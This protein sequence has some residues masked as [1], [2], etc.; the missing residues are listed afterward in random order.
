M[1]RFINQ[2]RLGVALLIF[3]IPLSM[4]GQTFN[5]SGK[6]VNEKKEALEYSSVVLVSKTDTTNLSFLLSDNNGSFEFVKVTAGSYELQILYNGYDFFEQS[7][8]LSNDLNLGEIKLQPSGITLKEAMVVAKKIPMVFKGDTIVYNPNS[9]STR[10]NASVEDLLKKLPGVQVLKDGTV[11]AQGENVVKVL[12]NGKE[13]FGDDPTKATKNIDADAVDKVEILERKTDEAR[14]K[15]VDDG[16]REK[17]I[18][19]VLKEEANKGYF[20]KAEVGGGTSETYRGKLTLNRFNEDNQYTIVAN[21]NNLNQNGFDWRE[22]Y[23][24]LG[25]SN[26]VSLGQKTYWSSQNEWLGQNQQGRQT[27]AVIGANANFKAGKK[28]NFNSS[29]FFM[30]RSNDLQ[31]SST[32][33]NFIPGYNIFNNSSSNLTSS[34]GQHKVYG[35]YRL[36]ADTLNFVTLEGE[37][38]YSYGREAKNNYAVNETAEGNLLNQ[39]LSQLEDINSNLNFKMKGSYIRKFR[40]NKHVITGEAGL[41]RNDAVDTSTWAILYSREPITNSLALPREFEDGKTGFGNQFFAGAQFDYHLKKK[42]FT[43]IRVEYK[44]GK[45][46]FLQNRTHLFND[47][48]VASQSPL[49]SSTYESV[50]YQLGLSKNFDKKGWFWGLYVSALNLNQKRELELEGAQTSNFEKAYLFLL[51]SA[52]AGFRI[53]RKGKFHI[54]MNSREMLPN[55]TQVNP[56]VNISNPVRTSQGNISLDP[57]VQHSGGASFRIQNPQKNIFWYGYFGAGF[58]P[59]VIGSQ[60]IRDTNNISTTLP[61]NLKNSGW[62]NGNLNYSFPIKKLKLEIDLGLTYNNLSYF[63]V[64]NGVTYQN[65]RNTIGYSVELELQL[66]P[67]ELDLGYEPDYSIQVS[68]LFEEPLN[69]WRHDLYTDLYL[70]LTNR[71][72]FNVE[73]SIYYF[74]GNQLG[75]QQLVPVMNSGLEWGIDSAKN[76]VASITAYD[77]LK[78]AQN[79]DRNFFGNGYTETRQNTLTRFFMISLAHTI[80]KGKKKQSGQRRRW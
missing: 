29:Y 37:A 42:L 28:G 41:L 34:N 21:V 57:Y 65:N 49:L 77:V 13:F 9:F 60:E 3:S 8:D 35:R 30:D 25:G 40:K 79:I 24:M 11:R 14:F 43:K 32:S 64:L 54:W 72:D 22:Y 74:N 4:S 50:K 66:G 27:N 46:S 2:I 67:V 58:S 80:K 12:V 33:E 20:G 47:S 7:Y 59:N 10:A 31:S 76:W 18:N 39:S 56:V 5:V 1:T 17:V 19:L 38:S 61:V 78:R 52:Y 75:G 70:E 53:P 26:G 15:G 55:I 16:T 73:T 48:L 71:I 44:N 6:I 23:R 69:Y 63:N 68:P 62:M 45:D 51:P 36:D